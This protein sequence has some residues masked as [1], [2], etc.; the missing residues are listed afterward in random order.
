MKLYYAKHVDGKKTL[1]YGG[2]TL[3]VSAPFLFEFLVNCV[4][5]KYESDLDMKDYNIF[6]IDVEE[7]R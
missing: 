4:K 6:S 5:D 2:N 1:Q 3:F 7:K